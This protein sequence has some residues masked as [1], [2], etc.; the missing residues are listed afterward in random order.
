MRILACLLLLCAGAARAGPAD[1]AFGLQLA[2][3]ATGG[4]PEKSAA[5]TALSELRHPNTR[6]VLGALL[7]GKLYYRNADNRVFITDGG[8]ARLTLT[9][10]L[11]LKPAG[12]AAPDDFSRITTNN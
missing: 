3:L 11:T 8:E 4:F 12:D 5:V 7:D 1:D 6:A 2:A 9:D 10:P